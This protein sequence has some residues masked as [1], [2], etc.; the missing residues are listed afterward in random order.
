MCRCLGKG[1]NGYCTP[2]RSQRAT[3]KGLR[4]I[5]LAACDMEGV[6]P[7]SLAACD[8]EGVAAHIA[9]SVRHG[10]GRGPYR[11]QRATWK[12]LRP[13]SL[14]A[15]DMEGVA[16]HIA[17]S[18]RHGRGCGP[19]RWQRATWKGLRPISLAACDMEGVAAHIAGSVR[20]GR[21]F[22]PYRRQHMVW[23]ARRSLFIAG[24]LQRKNCISVGAGHV[25]GK[26]SERTGTCG[27]V[28][29]PARRLSGIHSCST[30]AAATSSDHGNN[31]GAVIGGR[32][33]L[34]PLGRRHS[35]IAR[36]GS[37]HAYVCTQGGR[38]L[39]PD[40][41]YAEFPPGCARCRSKYPFTREPR[42]CGRSDQLYRGP[43]PWS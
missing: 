16:A 40:R 19:Y 35:Y 42:G 24:A 4:P 34:G 27:S 14:A 11:W 20:H 10:R 9:G 29:P 12:G 39:Q 28:C 38:A 32:P 26:R 2:Y 37:L 6:R 18:V 23:T 21:G 7:I 13:I 33:R 43:E 30:A 17:G 36:S 3:W 41:G 1:I 15:C 8:M 5:S 22:D 25:R 31:S